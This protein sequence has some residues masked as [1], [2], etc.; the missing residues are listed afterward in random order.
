M[1]VVEARAVDLVAP[2]NQDQIG[3]CFATDSLSR[4]VSRV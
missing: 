1:A 4:R 2:R 3:I